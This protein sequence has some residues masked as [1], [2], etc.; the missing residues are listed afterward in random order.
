MSQQHSVV[1]AFNKD[2]L[3]TIHRGGLEELDIDA[4]GFVANFE[5]HEL[6]VLQP[7]ANP[8]ALDQQCCVV[9][10]LSRSPE[11]ALSPLNYGIERMLFRLYLWVCACYQGTNS[12]P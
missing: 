6:I 1:T 8:L 7:L 10:D 2:D 12:Q 3:S 9:L 11:Y 5:F 4:Q